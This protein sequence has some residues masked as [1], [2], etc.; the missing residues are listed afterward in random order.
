MNGLSTN[1]GDMFAGGVSVYSAYKLWKKSKVGNIDRSTAIWAAV[2]V[3]IKV[4]AGV[5]TKNPVL[6][7]SGVMDTVISV[8]DYEQAKSALKK[9]CNILFSDEALA[10][11]TVA[12]TALASG[13]A[14]GTLRIMPPL[15][16]AGVAGY[17]FYRYME[18]EGKSRNRSSFFLKLNSRNS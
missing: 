17:A 15:I 12:G 18:K 2:G 3:G 1:V 7:I 14:L 10:C 11:L 13:A 4:T 16:V 9:F 5:I 8:L 6:I